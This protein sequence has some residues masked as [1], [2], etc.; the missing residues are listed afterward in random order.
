MLHNIT[1]IVFIAIWPVWLVLDLIILWKRGHHGTGPIPE[2]VSMVARDSG[3]RLSIIP[4]LWGAMATHY[5]WPG[6]VWGS[7]ADGIVFWLVALLLL[8]QDVIL[9]KRPVSTWPKWLVWQR[10]PILLLLV[11]AILGKLLFSQAGFVP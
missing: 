8:I 3:W 9:W 1:F 2:T 10:W 7:T 5:W 4:Y 11:G 6:K